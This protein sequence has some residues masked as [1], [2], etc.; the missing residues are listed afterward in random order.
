MVLQIFFRGRYAFCSFQPARR[1]KRIRS[2]YRMGKIETI[3]KNLFTRR[4]LVHVKGK[5]QGA[6]NNQG[7]VQRLWNLYRLL[8][9]EGPGA[10]RRG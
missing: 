4:G 1:I 3:V 6:K 7:L 5:A 8:P 2:G 10:G 9:E